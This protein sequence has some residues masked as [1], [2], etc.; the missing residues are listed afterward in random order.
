MS[1]DQKIRELQA[2]DLARLEA[3]RSVVEKFLAND[4]S[5]RKYRA[6]AAGKLGTLRA[7]LDA[8][9]FSPS[10]SY[11]LQCLGIV[12]GDAFVLDLGFR[13][14]MVED[15]YGI[16]PALQL[17]GTTLLLFP[18]TM[19]SKRVERGEEVDVFDLYNWVSAEMERM[20]REGM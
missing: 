2:E 19:I 10:Q 3:Q 12:L 20:K 18:L 13:W 8:G 5:R 17:K 1:D 6:T 7:L 14:V 15:A 4:D 16:D 9:V 11:E